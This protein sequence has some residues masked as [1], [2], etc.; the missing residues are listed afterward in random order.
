MKLDELLVQLLSENSVVEI[1]GNKEA[2]VTEIVYDTRKTIGKGSLFVCITGAVFDGHEYAETA[3]AAGASVIVAEK[4]LTLSGDAT[5]VLVKDTR[6]AL[7]YISAA[8]FGYPAKKLVTIGITGTKG[9]T[10]TAYM[11]HHI[12][13]KV[14]IKS[15]LVGTV[16]VRNGA[17][18]IP[19]SH[20]T[21]ES[22][23]LQKYFREMVDNGCKAVVMEVSSQAL[24]LH[25]VGG[26][27]FDYAVFTNLE[28]DHIGP[29]EHADFEDYA[30]CKSRLFCQCR[31]GILNGD[32]PMMNRMLMGSTCDYMTYGCG[33]GAD[34]QA[35]GI[36]LHR[37]DGKLMVSYATKGILETEIAVPVPGMFTVYNSLTAAAICMQFKVPT[38]VMKKAFTEVQVKGRLESIHLSPRFSLMID[39]AHNAMSLKSLLTAL[40][41]YRP[42][43]LVCLFGCGGNRSRD[44]RFEMGEISSRY[45]DLTIVTSDNPRFEEP[46]AII[47]DILTGVKKADGAYVTV[48]DRKEAIRYAILNA[49]DED[50]I[51]LAGKGHEDYQE[52]KGV[53]YPMDE[54]VLIREILSE[55]TPEEKERL[56]I[57]L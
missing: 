17:E 18:T 27:I 36:D 54:R 47:E 23:L 57:I 25:R 24:K 33:D 34:L 29:N 22:F 12:L 37:T 46:E 15:G 8:W 31:F 1:R 28:P 19:A 35:T 2:E 49:Q 48:P 50:V 7:A 44:R 9:K 14:G 5:L 21:P 43:R 6:K 40:K 30:E 4:E 41:E 10:T 26:V 42:K 39:Y 38:E 3:V 53:K 16:E 51:V 45:A 52:I 13:E 11:V 32:D 56:K 20:T 55:M